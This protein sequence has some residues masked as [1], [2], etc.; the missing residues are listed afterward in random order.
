MAAKFYSSIRQGSTT[1]TGSMLR[2]WLSWPR[3]SAPWYKN[4]L[5]LAGIIYVH[6][7]TDNRMTNTLL[8]NLSVIR[9]ICGDEPLRNVTIVTTFWY[10]EDPKTA[11]KREMEMLEKADWWGYMM[12]KGAKSRRFFNT[13]ESAHAILQEFIDRDRITLQIQTEMV[14]TRPRDQRYSSGKLSERRDHKACQA[15]PGGTR[16]SRRKD[17]RRR[18]PKRRQAARNAGPSTEE[19][20]KKE[21][22]RMQREQMAMERDRSE[23]MRRAAWSKPFKTNYS[24]SWRNARIAKP[25]SP[26]SR[27]S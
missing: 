14:R 1:P 6:R 5:Q 8:R 21:L 25:R 23:D 17:E 27:G 11:A 16:S 4:R 2:Y 22:T 24:A 19:K 3:P 13:E 9:N 10:K 7:I 12:E 18:T 26:N 20:R 15:A